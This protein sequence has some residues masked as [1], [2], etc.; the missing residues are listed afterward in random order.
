MA[1]M[2]GTSGWQYADWRGDFYPSEVPKSRWLEHYAEV[3]PT[4]E[5]NNAFYRLPER[6]VFES[7]YERTPPG[8]VMAV[9]ASRYLTH[10]KR[11]HQPTEPVARLVDRAS[12]LQEKLGPVLLQLPPTLRLDLGALEETLAA[13]PA[14]I[15][16]AVEPRHPSWFV[17]ETAELLSA[18]NAAHCLADSPRLRSPRWRTSDWGYLRLHEGRAS[19][20]P[21][22]G[23]RALHAWAERLASLFDPA[24]DIYVYFNND[25]GGCAPRNA[26]TF[27]R[28]LPSHGL[29]S[30]PSAGPRDMYRTIRSF[31]RRPER[32]K[33]II[34]RPSAAKNLSVRPAERRSRA[35]S[36]RPTPP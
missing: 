16:V 33:G 30:V 32:H 13:F 22:Y 9:K 19:P 35:P 4:L 5:V 24:D 6:S 11:L 34:A 36:C 18:H 28:I 15:R 8:F 21:C 7:W 31:A 2:V 23:V 14:G 26:Q 25:P 10:I 29:T 12:G 1:V 3:F 20:V 27:Q 17:E